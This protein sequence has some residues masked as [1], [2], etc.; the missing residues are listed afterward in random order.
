M[1]R[2][3]I[4]LS[5]NGHKYNGWQSQLNGITVQGQLVEKVSLLLKEEVSITGAGRTDTGVHARN[6]YA[7]FDN[8]KL[9]LNELDN[10]IHHLNS[11]LPH[12][13]A[14]KSI[15]PVTSDAHARFSAL[16]RSYEYLI[17][18][19]KDPFLEGFSHQYFRP[20]DVDI[21][22]K[23]C[24]LLLETSDFKAFSKSHTDVKTYVC[25]INNASWTSIDNQLI[26]NITADRFLRNMVRAIVGTMLE[27]G[28]GSKNLDD[29]R[30][31]ILSRERSSAGQS[32][33]PEGLYLTQ[34]IYPENIF[35]I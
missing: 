17:H 23:A 14:I 1:A 34:I 6:F 20:L 9:E 26:F 11:I 27:L 31:I 13:I 8:N 5:Y 29:F 19:K 18:F 22:Q 15:F 28:R 3:F 32:V 7:H 30:K 16:S 10:L 24:Q 2:F 35:K 33:P 12:D 25:K 21:M 4:H